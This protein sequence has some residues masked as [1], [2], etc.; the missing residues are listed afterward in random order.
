MGKYWDLNDAYDH[1]ADDPSEETLAQLTET[2]QR[3]IQSLASSLANGRALDDLVQAGNVGLLEAVKRYDPQRD[4]QFST[5]AY[6]WVMGEIRLEI[7]R[8][9]TFDRPLWAVNLQDSILKATD[10]FVTEHKRTPTTEEL[11]ELLNIEESSIAEAMQAGSVPFD[12]IKVKELRS[13]GP[14]SF[15]LPLEDHVLLSQ[16]LAKLTGLQKRVIHGLFFEGK[17]QKAVGEDLN[18]SRSQV[19]RVMQKSLKSLEKIIR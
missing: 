6:N 10:S 16:S 8:E 14:Q 7:R 17:T 4:A 18:M 19:F 5:Y 11:S 13:R 2:G 15:R 12:D 9:R 3:L 1:Y